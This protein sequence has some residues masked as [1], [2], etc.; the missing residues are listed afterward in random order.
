MPPGPERTEQSEWLLYAFDRFTE[1]EKRTIT[2]MMEFYLSKKYDGGKW[3]KKYAYLVCRLVGNARWES[4][5]Q[6][7]ASP[8]QPAFPPQNK[9]GSAN[10]VTMPAAAVVP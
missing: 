6:N 9:G 7:S 10:L 4:H 3:V 2:E 5:A 1:E 8:G